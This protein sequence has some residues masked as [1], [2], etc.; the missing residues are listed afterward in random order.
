MEEA[1]DVGMEI[2]GRD[3]LGRWIHEELIVVTVQSVL[4]VVGERVGRGGAKASIKGV[5]SGDDS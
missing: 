3:W 5:E 4:T 2:N 1:E